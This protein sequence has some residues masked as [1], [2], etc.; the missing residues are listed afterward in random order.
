MIMRRDGREDDTEM[1][2]W[3]QNSV[4]GASDMIKNR[5]ALFRKGNDFALFMGC[6]RS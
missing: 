6:K 3:L 4:V 2:R 1:G 5:F